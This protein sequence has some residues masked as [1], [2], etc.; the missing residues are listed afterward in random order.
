M[1][2]RLD[3][4]AEIADRIALCIIEARADDQHPRA[5]A[6]HR[7]LE[8]IPPNRDERFGSEPMRRKRH[9]YDGIAAR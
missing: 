1:R 9:V 3:V 4:D 7:A 5:Y 2:G 8:H 6:P